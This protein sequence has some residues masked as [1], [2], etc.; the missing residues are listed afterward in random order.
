MLRLKNAFFSYSAPNANIAQKRSMLRILSV[1][2]KGLI[3]II[4]HNVL[5]V[6]KT[7]LQ[8]NLLF[9]SCPNL[10]LLFRIKVIQQAGSF[11]FETEFYMLNPLIIKKELDNLIE[12]K[13]ENL[14]FLVLYFFSSLF[15]LSSNRNVLNSTINIF[16]GISIYTQRL[17][18]F[19]SSF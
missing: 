14:Q 7:L 11:Q 13:G 10:S 5:S 12:A 9:L 18:K 4:S 2:G 17:Y 15:H 3:M 8:S 6:L 16:I 1:V 19:L